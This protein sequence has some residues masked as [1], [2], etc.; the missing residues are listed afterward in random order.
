MSEST[1][2]KLRSDPRVQ[3]ARE[4]L[5]GAMEEHRRQL[6]GV[7]AVDP[8]R[9]VSYDELIAGFSEL[10]G[11][12]LFYRYIGSGVGN[13]ALVELAD[14]S[15]KYDMACGIGVHYLGHSDPSI[16]A[17]LIDASISD[18]VMQGNL[19]QNEDG[20]RVS[21]SLLSMAGRTGSKLAHCFLT[22]S[23]AMANEN[24]LKLIFHHRQPADR[25]LAFEHCF[26]GRTMALAHVTDKPAYRNGLPQTLN[27]DY[28]PFFDA[29]DPAGST[30]R[31]LA[32]LKQ[33]L[34]RHAGNL[35]RHAGMIMELI[36]GEG[37]YYPGDRDF[38]IAL[39]TELKKHNIAVFVDEI[40]TFGRTTQ[41]YAFQHFGVEE[42][43]DVVTV[44]KM[45]QVCATLFADALK[46]PPGLISQTF[47]G[48][49][50]A[51][52]ASQ[53]ILNRL[54]SGDLFGA[55]GRVARL[56]DYFVS[57]LKAMADDH[58]Q[59]VSGPFGCCGM[60]AFTPF[61][62]SA[63]TIRQLLQRL[64]DAGV[65]AFVTGSHPSRVR[66]LPPLAVMDEN[67]IDAVCEIVQNTL[68]Q[69][70]AERA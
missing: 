41:P 6:T 62:G 38:F 7:Q 1:A 53:A 21:Q 51:L 57:K 56:S 42:F 48:A 69:I 4:M 64:F 12:N 28:L 43:V 54:E 24:A 67:D 15:V 39:M 16:A 25:L 40:Q 30:K 9:K 58:P 66:F 5:L 61:D 26:A 35:G 11:G 55:D 17:A 59:Q 52:L 37:G 20:Y 46:P 44:G 27:V 50:S 70:A 36:Q 22:T 3:Q 18:V 29:N 23:G 63:D 14:G 8:S 68:A 49:T 2:D 31:T 33:H 65:I 47:T 60:I 13:G 19:Q 34:D 45:T 10:R 32:V